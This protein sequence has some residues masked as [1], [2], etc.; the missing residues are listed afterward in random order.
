MLRLA[1]EIIVS[2]GSNGQFQVMTQNTEVSGFRITEIRYHFRHAGYVPGASPW[3]WLALS[4]N[5][6]VGTFSSMT[7]SQS[8][9]QNVIANE[10]GQNGYTVI[11]LPTGD[12]LVDAKSLWC[13]F[14]SSSSAGTSTYT[15]EVFGEPVELTETERAFL[16][17]SRNIH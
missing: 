8:T 7:E 17:F 10:N 11:D 1:G 16:S 3:L 5:D 12:I 2:A 9:I 13:G 6:Q 4:H 14:V 15:C